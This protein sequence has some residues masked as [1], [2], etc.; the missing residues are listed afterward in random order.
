MPVSV[1]K[2]H[3]GASITRPDLAQHPA[4]RFVNEVMGIVKKDPGDM[5]RGCEL[6]A[7]DV[8]ERGQHGHAA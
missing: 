6:I 5:E 2:R 1:Q 4:D 7:L 3:F 8:I